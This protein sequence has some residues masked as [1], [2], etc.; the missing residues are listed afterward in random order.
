MKTFL[1][2]NA[3]VRGTNGKIRQGSNQSQ[4]QILG[5]LVILLLYKNNLQKTLTK[6]ITVVLHIHNKI[7]GIKLAGNHANKKRV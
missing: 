5:E 4:F 3:L 7:V 2:Y 1:L 6:V